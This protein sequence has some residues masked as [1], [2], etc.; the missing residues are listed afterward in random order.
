MIETYKPSGKFAP[1]YFLFLIG[2]FAIAIG[3]AWL[4]VRLLDLIPFIYLNF[5]ITAGMGLACAFILTICIDKGRC[6]NSILAILVG[7]LFGGGVVA[8]KHWFQY[9]HT[10]GMISKEAGQPVEEIEKV[11][12]FQNY[13]K[14]RVDNGW[15][16]GSGGDI[17]GIFVYIVW[18]TEA[19][20]I[21][22]IAFTAWKRSRDPFSEDVGLWAD[23]EEPLLVVPVYDYAEVHSDAQ[24]FDDLLDFPEL[25]EG[26]TPR[27]ILYMLN[28]I[29]GVDNHDSYL[30]VRDVRVTHDKEG[31]ENV[32][33]KDIFSFV[34]VNPEQ[35]EQLRSAIAHW[36]ANQA[37]SAQGG[38]DAD[39]D[40]EEFDA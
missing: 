40:G 13:I 23:E 9:R 21:L 6:R 20:V 18:A 3:L 12:S 39:V 2:G 24:S 14:L 7:L 27:A 33:T 17:S 16:M 19:F 35:R 28:S 11:V 36:E 10:L 22:A 34:R 38:V 37:L 5:L 32:D 1:T 29:E 15:T 8:T 31:K 26:H 25:C 30:S 4:Y